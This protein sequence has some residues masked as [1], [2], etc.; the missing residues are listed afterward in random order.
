MKS[1][2]AKDTFLY[3]KFTLEVIYKYVAWP[4]KSTYEIERIM[5]NSYR[6]PQATAPKIIL[7]LGVVGRAQTLP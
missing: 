4:E 6:K 1:G 5:M 7:S 2:C 3:E